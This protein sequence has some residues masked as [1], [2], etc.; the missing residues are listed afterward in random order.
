MKMRA[1]W[2]VAPCSLVEVDRRVRG[3]Y[4]HY[5]QSGYGGSAHHTMVCS[6]ETTS[7]T[8]QNALIFTVTFSSQKSFTIEGVLLHSTV[9]EAK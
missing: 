7:A 3:A 8:S 4:C 2:D 9:L 1:F 6:N 5:H